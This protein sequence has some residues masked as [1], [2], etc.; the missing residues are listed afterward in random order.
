MTATMRR[1]L[2]ML[3][4]VVAAA[5]GSGDTMVE[6]ECG[7]NK[8]CPM[9]FECHPV[10]RRCIMATATGVK[11]SLTIA[12]GGTVAVSGAAGACTTASCN[13][14][15]NSGT[16]VM[17]TAQ[18]KAGTRFVEWGG[19]CGGTNPTITV[20]MDAAKTCTATFVERVVVSAGVAGAAGATVTASSND[21]GSSCSGAMCTVDKGGNVTLTAST[22]AGSRFTGWSGTG[23]AG[24]APVL[25]LTGV[26]AALTCT[27]TY[28]PGL[29]VI[30]SVVGATGTIEARSTSPGASC[31][32]G[33]CTLD[34]GG[35]VTLT[36]PAIAGHRFT[37]W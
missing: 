32:A 3:C 1:L 29:A 21:P 7:P 20:T 37:G 8:T 13:F 15:F 28:V 17:L 24:S 30:G 22:V 5:C 35:T 19:A 9:G 33:G 31:S 34:P 26:T 25:S 14:D 18:P 10:D 12:G 36:A 16:Q 6:D 23:C 4:L 2:G 27:A 11:L